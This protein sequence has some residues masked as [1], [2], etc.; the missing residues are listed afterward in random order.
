MGPNK[1]I[2]AKRMLIDPWFDEIREEM[3]E[4]FGN[5]YPHCGSKEYQ[6]KKFQNKQNDENKNPN[7]QQK[8]QCSEEDEDDDFVKKGKQ[9]KKYHNDEE[10][11]DNDDDYDDITANAEEWNKNHNNSDLSQP[12]DQDK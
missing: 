3:I 9:S 1:R 11:S 5:V 10:D 12:M 2:T 7:I 4:M 8:K 6:L